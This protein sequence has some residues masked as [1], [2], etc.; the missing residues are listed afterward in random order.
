MVDAV[1]VENGPASNSAV[2]WPA[3]I[4]GAVVAA[5]LTLMLLA[6]G[7]G[8]GF[9][10]VSPWSGAPDLS[11]TTAATVAGI[12]PEARRVAVRS[13]AMAGSFS[14][15][16][17]VRPS[18]RAKNAYSISSARTPANLALRGVHA[19]RWPRVRWPSRYHQRNANG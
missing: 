12:A 8:L 2:S 15:M 17:I 7:A 13:S 18:R 11:S 14:T 1:I 5:A 16:R 6:L 3:I 9:S 19:T 10:V 4:A